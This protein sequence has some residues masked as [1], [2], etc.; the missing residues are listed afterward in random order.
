M[1]NDTARKRQFVRALAEY[2]AGNS[3]EKSIRLEMG[4]REGQPL[5]G[6]TKDRRLHS[7]GPT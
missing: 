1:E 3:A 2:L 4:M 5:V 7:H 6:E